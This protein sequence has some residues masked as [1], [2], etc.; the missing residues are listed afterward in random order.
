VV[1]AYTAVYE[2]L[3]KRARPG[4]PIEATSWRVLVSGPVPDLRLRHSDREATGPARKGE[5]PVYFPE[6]GGY[7]PTPVYDRYALRSG[8]HLAGPAI[9][10]ERESTVV[11]GPGGQASVDEYQN[12]R[13]RIAGDDA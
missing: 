11:V 5:R 8:D 9:V 7:A 12:L 1:A 13:V 10:E 4:V 3:Y 6:H 2:Q